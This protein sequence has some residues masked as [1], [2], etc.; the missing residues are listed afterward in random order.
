MLFDAAGRHDHT[1]RRLV[2]K[3]AVHRIDVEIL[4]RRPHMPRVRRND[5]RPPGHPPRYPPKAPPR[6]QPLCVS[7]S[8]TVIGTQVTPASFE[9]AIECR[10]AATTFS[11][12]DA[13]ICQSR[14]PRGPAGAQVAPLSPLASSPDEVVAS[15]VPPA[16]VTEYTLPSN[17]FVATGGAAATLPTAGA[18][19][20]RP[21][22]SLATV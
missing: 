1:V 12:A 21:I 14:L 8:G 20:A 10:P 3:N 2:E 6:R 22:V 15:S 4:R 5:T 17:V 9:N 16:V 11:F 13:I 19:A 7:P 18:I